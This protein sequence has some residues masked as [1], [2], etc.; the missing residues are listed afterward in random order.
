M[1]KVLIDFVGLILVALLGAFVFGWLPMMID[2][3]RG[4]E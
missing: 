2:E 1:I 4:A 3:K